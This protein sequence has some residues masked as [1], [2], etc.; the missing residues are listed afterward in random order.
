[1]FTRAKEINT[2]IRNKIEDT[3]FVDSDLYYFS[4][5]ISK[6]KTEKIEKVVGVEEELNRVFID[7]EFGDLRLV[8][9]GG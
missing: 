6:R 8:N 4:C 2:K 1:M 7:K 5:F 3:T 9:D